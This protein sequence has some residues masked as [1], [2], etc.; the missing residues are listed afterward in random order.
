MLF[1][2]GGVLPTGWLH[3]CWS[4]SVAG[5]LGALWAWR[6]SYGVGVTLVNGAIKLIMD[7]PPDPSVHVAVSG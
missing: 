1:F 3:V 2:L 7:Q 4:E 5:Y 6:W